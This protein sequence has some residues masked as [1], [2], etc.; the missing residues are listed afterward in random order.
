MAFLYCSSQVLLFT[1]HLRARS[2]EKGD[3]NSRLLRQEYLVV[4]AAISW[5]SDNIGSTIARL[6]RA[7][8]RVPAM[9]PTLRIALCL[10]VLLFMPT[11]LTACIN[12][13]ADDLA[14]A[15][16]STDQVQAT[17]FLPL[18]ADKPGTPVDLRRYLV[19]GKYTIVAFFSPYDA[20][21]V[22]LEPRLVRLAQVRNDIAVRTLNVN[23]AGARGIDWQSPIVE[24]TRIPT[25]PYLLIYDP[26]L[27]LRA[28][29]PPAYEQVIQWVRQLPN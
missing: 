3:E 15:K 8:R 20:R 14:V 9:H 10:S 17:N 21:S 12:R 11:L 16:L 18:N 29:G 25:L 6:T 2:R 23:R 4:I 26:G 27:S 13:H 1:G 28:K 7:H 22:L 24:N 5:T 19:R